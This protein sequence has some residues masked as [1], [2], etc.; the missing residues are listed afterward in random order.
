MEHALNGQC[1]VHIDASNGL[2]LIRLRGA[3]N[4]SAIAQC[5]QAVHSLEEW[6]HQFDVI[7]FEDAITFLEVTPVQLD[8]M[9]D[10]QTMQEQGRDI[11][12]TARADY[13]M[14]MTLY[15]YRVRSR[16]RPAR[17][18]NT[19]VEALDVVGLKELPEALAP[20][21]EP[22]YVRRWEI[23]PGTD[24]GTSSGPG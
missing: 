8:R 5:A 18:C 22:T 1:T 19:L 13:E 11:I 15:T 24:G 16:G 3:A 17:V 21:K 2:A 20:H 23:H 12:V 6:D 9:V 7:W 10:A 14:I 4:G